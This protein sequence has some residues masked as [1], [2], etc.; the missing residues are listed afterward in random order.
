[1]VI[2]AGQLLSGP[3]FLDVKGT[4]LQEHRIRTQCCPISFQ[5][6]PLDIDAVIDRLEDR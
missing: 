2:M 6:A 3:V 5:A 1:M 4:D